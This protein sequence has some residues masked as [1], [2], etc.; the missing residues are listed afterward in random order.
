MKYN[1]KLILIPLI[2]I[3]LTGCNK[4][5]PPVTSE[6]IFTS[7]DIVLMKKEMKKS[8]NFFYKEVQDDETSPAYGLIA[9]VARGNVAS[10]AS[11]GFGLAAMPIGVN[12]GWITLEDAEKRVSGTLDTLLNIETINGFYYH[13]LD[14]DTGMRSGGSELSVI[15][16]GIMVIG[17]LIAG[18]YF[19]GE[20]ETKAIAIY[21][22]VNWKW[23]TGLNPNGS[24]PQFRMSY[25][26][27]THLFSGY[28]DFYAEQLMLYV[29]GAGSPN[30]DF[31]TDKALY[32]GF[33]RARG[34][35]DGNNFIY[36]WF[37]SLFT[38]QYSHAFIDF[39][40][41]IDADGVD[42]FQ[43]SVDAS[44]ASY[45]YCVDNKDRIA[46]FSEGSWG[47]T[48]CDTKLGYSGLLGTPPRGFSPS[49][50][51]DYRKI[52]GTVAPAAALGSMPFT[53]KYS[54]QALRN[55]DSN[56]D[57]QGIYGFYDSYDLVN[58]WYS[59]TYIGIDKGITLLMLANALDG[60]IWNLSNKI[61]VITLG[62][63]RIGFVARDKREY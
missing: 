7:D 13:F 34:A 47:L 32:D 28:W 57:L 49:G 46:T 37:G 12:E 22:R 11:V 29:L 58:K 39:G 23:Y 15:D 44:I 63:E 60:F 8:F 3:V 20:I 27:D 14:M 4:P 56:L 5:K 17:A 54:L 62:L 16:T 35:Y 38:Y 31:R 1:H 51:P 6:D 18:E 25:N 21:E 52:E 33:R 45:D 36:S 19:K 10:V 59:F 50:D 43:N 42:W 53:P 41:Y 26:P 30:V 61:D 2:A 55:Y 24:K 9:D 40:S 48:A